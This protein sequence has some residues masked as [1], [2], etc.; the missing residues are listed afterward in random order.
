LQPKINHLEKIRVAAVSYLNTRPLLYGIKH[1]PVF[2]KIE[3]VE[4]Y[5]S[6]IATM[7][8]NNEVDVGLVP[9]AVIPSLKQYHIITDYCIGADGPVASVCLF[10]EVPVNEIKKVYLDYQS[11]TSVNLARILLKEYWQTN[12]EFINATGEDYREEIKGNSAAVIIGDRALAQRQRSGYIYD[13]AEAWKKHTGLPFVF[14]AWIS[15]KPLPEDFIASFNEANRQGLEALNEVVQQN[16]F[17]AF[18]LHDYYTRY[19]SYDL[20]HEKKK[21]LALF[22]NKLEKKPSI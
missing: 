10:S 12:P 4:E 17:P 18:D 2:N 20:T 3:L 15:N 21:G 1:H 7:L 8:L 13:L 16:P 22:L 11:M 6:K 9:V 5:P 19:I 14:A